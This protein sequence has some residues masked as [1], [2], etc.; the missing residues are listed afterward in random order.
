[1]GLIQC[2]QHSKSSRFYLHLWKRKRKE[3]RRKWGQ[4]EERKEEEKKR[5]NNGLAFLTPSFLNSFV[6]AAQC[7]PLPVS[8]NDITLTSISYRYSKET[9]LD[10]SILKDKSSSWPCIFPFLLQHTSPIGSLYNYTCISLL[11]TPTPLITEISVP[12]VLSLAP[13]TYQTHSR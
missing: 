1:M 4:K 11:T 10:N 8:T 2:L 7:Q 13:R 5:K 12:V 3:G 6:P 9:S